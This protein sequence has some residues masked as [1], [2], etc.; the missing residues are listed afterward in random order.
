MKSVWWIKRDF[1]I[2]D[3]QCLDEASK[4]SSTLLPFF[5][6]EPEILNH[7]D[8]SLFHLQAQMEGVLGLYKSL[9]KRGLISRVVMGNIVEQ[10]ETLFKLY[11]FQAIYSHQETGNLISFNRDNTVRKWCI[12]RGIKWIEKN[13]C[14]VMRGGNADQRRLKLRQS[15]FRK[16]KPLA[17]P[18]FEQLKSVPQPLAKAPLSWGELTRAVPKFSGSNQNSSLVKVDEKSAL[19][20][21]ASFLENRGIGYAGGISSP[22]SAFES[23]SRLSSHLAWGTISLRSVFDQLD[24]RR[25]ELKDDH[26]RSQWNRSL[27]AFESRLFWRDHFIQRLEA[28]PEL[29]NKALNSA[30][31]DLIYEDDLSNLDAWVNGRTGYPMVDACMRCLQECGFLNFRMRAMVVSFACYGLHL[32]WKTIHEPLAGMFH[33]YEP[34]I[35]LSQLQMQAGVIGFNAIRVYSPRKQF[36]D[37]DPNALFVRK[38]IPE[39]RDKTPAEIAH[40]DESFIDGYIPGIVNLKDRSQEMKNRVFAIRKSASAKKTTQKMLKLHG[41]QKQKKPQR[42][43]TSPKGQMTLFKTLRSGKT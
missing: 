33:D 5:C 1:R 19:E 10:L 9:K 11:P 25:V 17:I 27:R 39:L 21:V 18:V 41:S 29:E 13:P 34:G 36:L 24:K 8:Y 28:F 35:H 22:N 43:K 16:Q 12:A 38:W 7:G 26:D 32:S 42:K 20:T 15:D 6:W 3:N 31:A 37:H 14:S 40:A 2:S 30:Y 23:G 4:Q